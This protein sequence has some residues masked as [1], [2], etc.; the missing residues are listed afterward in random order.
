MT[1]SGNIALH[2]KVK[3]RVQGVGFRPFIYRTAHNLK[4]LGYVYNQPDGVIVYIEGSEENCSLFSE[5][6]RKQAPMGAVIKSIEIAKTDIQKPESFRILPSKSSSAAITE[7]CPDIAVCPDCLSELY[8][9]DRRNGYPFINCTNCGPRFTIVND[10]PYDRLNT[11]M[12]EFQM[13][14]TCQHEY[15]DPLDR[16]FHAQPTCCPKCGPRYTFLDHG[17]TLTNFSLILQALGAQINNG[18]VLALKGLGGYNLACDATEQTAVSEIRRFKNREK[19]PFAVMFQSIDTLRKYAHIG[20]NEADLLQS[21]RRPIVVLNTTLENHLAEGITAGLNTVGAFLPY[22]PLHY[23]LF[24]ELETDALVLTSGNESD[25]PILYTEEQ[26]INVFKSLSGGIL[27]NNRKIARRADDS[28]VR[29][30]D[31]SLCIMRRSRGYAPDPVDLNFNADGILATGAELSNCFC[32]GKEKQAILSQHIGDLKNAD[33][34]DFFR[35]NIREYSRIYKFN[36]KRVACDMHPDYL[37][38]LY[39]RELDMEITEVQHHHAHIAAVMAE[40]GLTD[41]VIGL[42]YDGTGYGTDGHI[43]GSELM[44]V[45]LKSFQ[46]INHFEYLPSPGGDSVTKEPWR[47]AL[48]YLYHVF[49]NDWKSVDIPYINSINFDKAEKLITAMDKGINSPL[50][51]SAGRLFDAIAALLTLCIESNYHAEAP[52]RL[53]DIVDGKFQESYSFQIGSVVSFNKMI[54]EITDDITDRRS[55]PEISTKFHNTIA[56]VAFTQ[57]KTLSEQTSIRKVII[58]GGT[59]QNRYLTEKLLHLL[60]QTDF[61]VYYPREIPCNDGGIALGQLAI[62]AHI[63]QK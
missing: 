31:S 58:T 5:I 17:K 45:D 47:S 19:K 15:S 27:T 30:M 28:V 24:D 7:I 22:L 29:L 13:C 59:F 37:S 6:L 46:R 20:T 34:F 14:E 21:W 23:L 56:L 8:S 62:A 52:M 4:L 25:V 32:I 61:E 26:A 48:A 10:F 39:A 55:A 49:G 33:T 51:C 1:N 16:R 43:W 3:G 60:R 9:N 63:K 36:P 41:Q 40:F 42:S 2:I 53:E 12:Q 57:I 11:T 50:C 54:H 38:T 44:V 18:R 35:E